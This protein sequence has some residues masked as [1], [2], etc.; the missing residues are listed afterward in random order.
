M[1]PAGDL[2]VLALEMLTPAS[3]LVEAVHTG[4]E[5]TSHAVLLPLDHIR[6]RALA[7]TLAALVPRGDVAVEVMATWN[8]RAS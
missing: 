3:L 6:L 2:D 5:A 4:D 8:R 7:V 1:T